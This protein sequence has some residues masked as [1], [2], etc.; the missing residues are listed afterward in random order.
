MGGMGESASGVHHAAQRRGRAVAEARDGSLLEH[1]L[2]GVLAP[3]HLEQAL[4][5]A[6]EDGEARG[7]GEDA[8]H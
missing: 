1:L 8:G 3:T 5:E 4:L 6:I 7:D 2:V